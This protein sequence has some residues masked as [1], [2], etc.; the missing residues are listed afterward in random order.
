MSRFHNEILAH[1]ANME[2]AIN[3]I[4]ARTPMFVSTVNGHMAVDDAFKDAR[5]DIVDSS[6]HFNSG[7]HVV[8][9]AK[10]RDGMSKHED[11]LKGVQAGIQGQLSLIKSGQSKF[12]MNQV[13]KNLDDLQAS[14]P[15]LN[16]AIHSYRELS[17]YYADN[18]EKTTEEQKAVEKEKT[19][20]ARNVIDSIADEHNIE[21][22]SGWDRHRGEESPNGE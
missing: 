9:I 15:H 17:K 16:S 5:R 11:I 8:A 14:L 18:L 21:L 3:N 19:D 22:P 4:H 1:F 20:N 2:H 10:L 12:T 6:L 13:E 7:D